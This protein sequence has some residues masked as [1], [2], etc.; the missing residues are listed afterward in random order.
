MVFSTLSKLVLTDKDSQIPEAIVHKAYHE[1]T[2][3][4]HAEVAALLAKHK[5]SDQNE[6]E[7]MNGQVIDHDNVNKAARSTAKD[8]NRSE[9]IGDGVG[10]T[11]CQTSKYSEPTDRPNARCET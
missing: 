5:T 3:S 2:E 6:L 10:A 7:C 8:L 4:K 11:T 1:V 9:D